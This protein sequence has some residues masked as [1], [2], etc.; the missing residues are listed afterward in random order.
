MDKKS[1]SIQIREKIVQSKKGDVFV[2][3]DFFEIAGV[4]AVNMTL[5]RL[6]KEPFFQRFIHGV[7]FFKGIGDQF[8]SGLRPYAVTVAQAIARS[9]S[10]I[11]I[12]YGQ[13]A[14]YTLGLSENEPATW[15]FVSNGIYREYRTPDYTLVFRKTANR[16]LTGIDSETALILQALKHIGK[17]NLSDSIIQ[18][19]RDI[20][21]EE[22]KT[23]M[24]KQTRHSTYWIHDTI[25]KIN[26][27]PS[28]D[29]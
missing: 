5:S 1:I 21:T 14:M 16:D 7:Y 13:T 6:A 25:R 20:F 27:R 28:K 8:D 11:I 26:E 23:R 4:H 19:L 24:L 17:N 22:E 3:L 15:V 12:P 10:W 2:P 18:R 29:F 9:N